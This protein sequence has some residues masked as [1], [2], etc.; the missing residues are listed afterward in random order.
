[1]SCTFLPRM[2]GY[3]ITFQTRGLSKEEV[4]LIWERLNPIDLETLIK[5]T[6][7]NL[8][9]WGDGLCIWVEQGRGDNI[10]VKCGKEQEQ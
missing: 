2:S 7:H 5:D 3:T 9:V 10:V 4:T 8:C 1:M 6:G